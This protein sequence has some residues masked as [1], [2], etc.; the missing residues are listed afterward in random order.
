LQQFCKCFAALNANVTK[1]HAL[2]Q[3]F[4]AFAGM[5]TPFSTNLP[6]AAKCHS[7]KPADNPDFN[8]RVTILDISG[9]EGPENCNYSNAYLL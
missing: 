2:F 3:H 8:D 4:Y 5:N 9:S 1:E 7:G 6:F